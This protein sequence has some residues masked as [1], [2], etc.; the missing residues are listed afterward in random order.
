[1]E[2]ITKTVEPI[3]NDD[4]YYLDFISNVLDNK[5]YENMNLIRLN[6]S[7]DQ[8]LTKDNIKTFITIL[9]DIFKMYAKNLKLKLDVSKNISDLMNDIL[10][11][12]KDY[13]KKCFVICYYFDKVNEFIL[14]KEKRFNLK[15]YASYI[16]ENII[17]LEPY[18]ND[19]GIKFDIID[20]IYKNIVH[21]CSFNNICNIHKITSTIFKRTDLFGRN[22]ISPNVIDEFILRID[23]L[24][25]KIY[26]KIVFDRECENYDKKNIIDQLYDYIDIIIKYPDPEINSKYDNMFKNRFLKY[27]IYLDNKKI[28]NIISIEILISSVLR[29]NDMYSKV[30]DKIK[31]YCE[32]I[33]NIKKNKD[34]IRYLDYNLWGLDYVYHDGIKYNPET[35]IMKMIHTTNKNYLLNLNLIHYKLLNQIGLH[36]KITFKNLIRKVRMKISKIN[37]QLNTL[38]TTELIIS[39]KIEGS[40]SFEFIINKNFSNQ[41][42]N[43]NLI[44]IDDEIKNHF[45]EETNDDSHNLKQFEDVDDSEINFDKIDNIDNIDQDDFDDDSEFDD[46]KS[47]IDKYEI[48]DNY[49]DFNSE[50]DSELDEDV[51]HK[52]N[53]KNIYS[54][55]YES[56]DKSKD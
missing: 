10:E 24:F 25:V 53:A 29:K 1:M 26:D 16:F 7:I 39:N 49:L 48:K 11:I 14:Q 51:N 41:S 52:I 18:T 19:D 32:S 30:C 5:E 46:D 56:E 47:E 8:N 50:E 35:T 20:H 37:I 54:D 9:Q 42:R 22:I 21:E 36:N 27:Y 13:F 28:N 6:D 55:D 43:I 23:E 38:I 17:Y 12:R 33:K 4:E 40:D 31:S 15:N 44:E 3:I 2:V 34:V 45:K